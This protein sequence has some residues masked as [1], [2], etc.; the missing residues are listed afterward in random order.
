MKCPKCGEEL[1]RSKKDQNYGL[2]DNYR[3]KYKWV[4]DYE[5]DYDEDEDYIE[6][7]PAKRKSPP[8]AK[9]HSKRKKKKNGILKWI[10]L[11]VFI[12]LIIAGVC[13]WYFKIKKP[14]DEAEAQFDAAAKQV[15]ATNT[16]LDNAIS[17]AKSI[18]DANEPVYDQTTINDITVAISEAEQGKRSIPDLPE[19][20]ADIITATEQMLEPIDY[21]S[22]I[23]NIAEKKAA[24]ENS[25][26]QMKQITNP[27]EDFV[28]LRLQGIEGISVCQAATEDHDPNG[29]LNKQGGYTAAIY[30][31]SPWINQDEVYGNDIVEKGTDCGGGVEVYVSAEDAENRNTYLAAFDGPG[32]LNPGS[33]TV[34]GT[35]VIRT[36]SLLTA[37]QQN[38]LTQSISTRLL[39][40]QE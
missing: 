37:T 15:N 28:I 20:T 32:M 16:D 34:L 9:S 3:K 40:L 24:L 27:S 29:N 4:D 31:S 38:E 19:K 21:S 1:R 23:S 26:K 12:I 39:E 11:I 25:I 30:F 2:C 10:L 14:H 17:S 35:M 8:N 33:H 18:L 22:F 7:Q 13:F 5:D 6:P 36:S